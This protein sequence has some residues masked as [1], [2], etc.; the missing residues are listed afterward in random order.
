MSHVTAGLEEEGVGREL[1]MVSRRELISAFCE[2][3]RVV[4]MGTRR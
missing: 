3:R 4:G 1:V 2:P